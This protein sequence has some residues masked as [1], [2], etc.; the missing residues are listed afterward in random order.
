MPR[1]SKGARLWLRPSRRRGNS[2]ANA[3]WIIID[4]DRHIATG[5]IKSQAREAEKRLAAYITEKYSP[6]RQA[7]DVDRIDVADVLSI[8]LED[9]GPRI[10]DQPKLERCI[11]R[12]N[13]YWSGKVLSQVTAAECR[14]FVKQRVRPVVPVPTSKPCAPRS[15]I[16]PRRTF[17]TVSFASR[18]RQR[19]SHGTDGSR[20]ARPR[21]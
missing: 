18:C 19:D 5:C 6:A 15:I 17:I 8:Y 20:A 9:C 16:M 12:L 1:P 13:D 7:R 11:D 21:S 4:G 3:V 10:T 14:A 2:V